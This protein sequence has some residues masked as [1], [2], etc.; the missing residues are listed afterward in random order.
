[1]PRG[2][3]RRAA[4]FVSGEAVALQ[5][6]VRA[7]FTA[8]KRLERLQRR[9]GRAHRQHFP[10][11]ALARGTV[12][13]PGLF[14]GCTE[15]I[16]ESGAFTFHD[17]TGREI[18]PIAAGERGTA[19]LKLTARGR[20]GHGSKVKMKKVTVGRDFGNE[21]EI[22]DGLTMDEPVVTN[23]GERLTDGIE[24]QVRSPQKKDGGANPAQGK[25]PQASAR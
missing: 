17:G 23:P 24:V 15:G 14:E 13:H 3:R 8:A 5:Q 4:G 25:A 20:A 10:P 2:V 16:S 22:A 9:T 7:R 18:Y 19:W 11:E 21:A 12:E 1:M 6:G